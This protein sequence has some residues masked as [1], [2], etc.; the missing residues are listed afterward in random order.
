[1][2]VSSN[3]LK[4]GRKIFSVK[5]SAPRIR[6]AV[7]FFSS[8]NW[9]EEIRKLFYA[10]SGGGGSYL[11]TRLTTPM[12]IQFFNYFDLWCVKFGVAS[13]RSSVS[14]AINPRYANSKP[15]EPPSIIISIRFIEKK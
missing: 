4:V 13:R 5:K 9:R 8:G 6:S 3:G 7:N 15:N 10:N 14:R 11:F 1:M 2:I 12:H